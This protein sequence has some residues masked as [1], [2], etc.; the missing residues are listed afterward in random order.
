QE[1][2]LWCFTVEFDF[3]KFG[4]ATI[5]WTGKRG[6]L[7]LRITMPIAEI[8]AALTGAHNLLKMGAG[9]LKLSQDVRVQ[10]AVIDI[11]HG[12]IDLQS[13][14]MSVQ[15]Q[16]DELARAKEEVE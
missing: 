12:V 15:S 10:Q 9:L 14:L 3:H 16:C 7:N 6:K 11:N 13:K 2:I 1:W 8:S 4:R 5:D